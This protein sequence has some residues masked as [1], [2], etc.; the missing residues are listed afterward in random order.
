M[1]IEDEV[2]P[3]AIKFVEG[4]WGIILPINLKT[5]DGETITNSDNFVIKI[6]EKINE[7]P[8]IEKT[9]SNIQN[10][11]I[12]FQLTEIDTEKLPVGNYF[13]DLDWYQ[14]NNFLC[15]LI[16]KEKLVVIEKAGNVD[17]G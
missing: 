15:N 11:T 14:D 9:F 3:L 16:A 12:E 10:N 1:F 2:N 8:L 7:E 13:Y 6:F 17:E 5:E 4:D